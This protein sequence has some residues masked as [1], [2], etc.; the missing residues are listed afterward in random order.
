[1][2]LGRGLKV[3]RLA[4]AGE[5]LLHSQFDFLLGTVRVRC[6][7]V[8]IQ[9]TTNG[10]LL[11]EAKWR[12][13]QEQGI[14]RLWV[15][16]NAATAAT[17]AR[18][19]PGL[20]FDRVCHNLAAVKRTNRGTTVRISMVATRLNFH[21][22]IPF[23]R[24]AREL[25]ADQVS[26]SA[27]DPLL[28]PPGVYENLRIPLEAKEHLARIAEEPGPVR[29][30]PASVFW[31]PEEQND[32]RQ[33]CPKTRRTFGVFFPNSDVQFCCYMAAQVQSIGHYE[34]LALGVWNG[35]KAQKWRNEGHPIC[36]RCTA[37]W[38]N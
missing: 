26:I 14:A 13:M 7:S 2:L 5:P 9:V 34:G 33:D 27:L 37:Q 16:L 15:S 6:P 30:S 1:M 19:M 17:Y 4:G 35:E 21:E 11:D 31:P 38:R 20:D 3:V 18:V 10:A 22:A 32:V 29:C 25:G 12:S 36:R 23:I 8:R 28:T 24:L